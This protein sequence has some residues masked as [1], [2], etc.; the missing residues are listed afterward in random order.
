MTLPVV[1]SLNRACEVH[2]LIREGHD[3]ILDAFPSISCRTVRV[4]PSKEIWFEKALP[5]QLSEAKYDALLDFSH[6]PEVSHLTSQLTEIPIRAITYDPE[7]DKLLRISV[8]EKTL[9]APFNRKV[10]VET[11]LHQVAKMQHLIH[12]ALGLD[13]VPEW[14]LPPARVPESRLS[15]FVHPHSDRPEKRWPLERFHELLVKMSYRRH[16]GVFLNTGRAHEA[17]ATME[18][19]SALSE[20]GIDA[21]LVAFDPSFQAMIG[22]LRRCHLALGTDSGP[23]HLASLLG[24]PTTV[25]FGRY[26]ACQFRPLYRNRAVSPPREQPASV[27]SVDEVLNVVSHSD[28][29]W[30]EHAPVFL[31]GEH[32]S[33]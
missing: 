32:A 26:P 6:W 8:N 10:P 2:W 1:Q 12:D 20:S 13:I 30:A 23:L 14:Q 18:L 22:N 28:L 5:E 16:L 24:V 29:P 27:I 21:E 19:Q 17:Q 11:S 25:I 7:L 4:N 15:I 33:V 3:K 31:W 9:Y